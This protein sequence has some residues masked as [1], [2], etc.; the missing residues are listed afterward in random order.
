MSNSSGNGFLLMCLLQHD[1]LCIYGSCEDTPIQ[2]QIKDDVLSAGFESLEIFRV[3]D[4]LK[5]KLLPVN[6]M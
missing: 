2:E 3:G 5:I 4:R 1:S 6:Q